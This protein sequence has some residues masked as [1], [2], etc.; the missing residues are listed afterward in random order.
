MQK[1]LTWLTLTKLSNMRMVVR[2]WL[3][4]SAWRCCW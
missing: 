1:C 2:A 3:R 4:S